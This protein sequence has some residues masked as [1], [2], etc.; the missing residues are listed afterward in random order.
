M[1][2]IIK[3]IRTIKNIEYY[4]LAIILILGFLARLYKIN[5]PVADWHSFR[6]AD[7]ASVTRIYV[8]EGINFLYPRY[9][10]FSATQSRLYNPNGYRF[11]ELPVFNVVH[12]ILVKNFPQLSLEVWGRLVAIFSSLF[13]VYMIFLLGK[14]FT[15]K[16]GGLLA[17]GF[18]ALLPFNIYFTRV[19]LPDPMAVA[20]ALL[21]L[22]FFVRFMDD[23]KAPFLYLSGLLFTVSILIKPFTA[24]Y[25]VPVAYLFL[26]E[27]K[28]KE[29]IKD[30]KLFIRL[31]VFVGIILIPFFAWRAWIGQYPAGIPGWQ[32]MFN[33]DHIRFR[34]AFWR[35]IFVERLGILILG[36]WGL[37]PF[38]FGLLKTKGKD[39]FIQFFLLGM[40]FYTVV[41]ATANVRHDYYQTI[42]IPAVS[43]AFA[44][45]V[46]YMWETKE[47]KQF[48]SR[49]LLVFSIIMMLGGTAYRV[50]EYY[51]INHPEI[52]TAGE[53]VD[54]IVPKDAL[55]IAPY[56]GDTAFLYQTKR[57]GWPVID[58]SLE[59]LIERGADYYVSVS[60]NDTDTV[61]VKENYQVIEETSDY[62]II[63]L[64]KPL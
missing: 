18:F 2:K 41:F 24:F 54:R 9:H 12:A 55:V 64:H 43:L 39:Y 38:A 31:V 22:W 34:P 15:N 59:E 63:D 32:W 7:T 23:K 48:L 30:S 40:L 29:I 36:A 11:V 19:I 1:I 50:K 10:D 33:G 3:Q 51:K 6:Q 44:Q 57:K 4:F 52:I 56:N 62:I 5:N 35:W 46:L 28:I 61:M 37:I 8:E 17:A 42:I 53:A 60:L 27:H 13:S 25:L 14:R 45:G 20:F 49:S 21:A 16:W 58:T 47:F 26:R